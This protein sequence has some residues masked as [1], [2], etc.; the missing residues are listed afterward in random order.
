M[1]LNRRRFAIAAALATGVGWFMTGE[2]L[3]RSGSSALSVPS[4]FALASEQDGLH[5]QFTLC[6][7]SARVNCMVDGDT[8]W[9]RGEKIRVADIDAPE[10]SEPRCRAE[11]R[12]GEAARNRL[13][14]L[15]NEGAFSLIAGARDE[16]RYGRKLRTVWQAGTSLGE[17]LVA[18]G[19]AHRWGGPRFGWC[20]DDSG[21][22]RGTK[23]LPTSKMQFT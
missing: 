7:R 5:A 21:A 19:L 2:G 10:I 4:L 20:G 22:L 16:D 23:F 9:F 11:W 13:L 17:R 14:V 6:G 8:F 12:R 15:L 18:E 1:K 3:G